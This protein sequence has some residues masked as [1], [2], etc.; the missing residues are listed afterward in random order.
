MYLSLWVI[1][2]MEK[3]Q[4]PRKASSRSRI[5]LFSLVNMW[6]CTALFGHNEKRYRPEIRY[7]HYSRPYVKTVVWHGFFAYLLDCF[8]L[9]LFFRKVTLRATSIE[10]FSHHVD[11]RISLGLPCFHVNVILVLTFIETLRGETCTFPLTCTLYKSVIFTNQYQA[12]RGISVSTG[13]PPFQSSV[14]PKAPG[15]SFWAWHLKF[16]TYHPCRLRKKI[17]NFIFSNFKFLRAIW[18]PF[19]PKNVKKWPKKP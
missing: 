11:F 1:E 15:H 17:K 10:S 6:V 9:S 13:F 14:C 12:Q 5:F 4:N 2:H 7:T 3:C 19:N 16:G 8:F 18:P